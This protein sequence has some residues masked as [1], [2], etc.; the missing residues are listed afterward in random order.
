[1]TRPGDDAAVPILRSGETAGPFTIELPL[2]IFEYL[3]WLHGLSWWRRL[4]QQH[5]PRRLAARVDRWPVPP[6][7]LTAYARRTA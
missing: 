7:V 3:D 2:G 6:H 4:I 1:M 5:A